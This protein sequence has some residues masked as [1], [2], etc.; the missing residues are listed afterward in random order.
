MQHDEHEADLEYV[1]DRDEDEFHS[2]SDQFVEAEPPTSSWSG[3]EDDWTIL[4]V[5]YDV[6]GYRIRSAQEIPAGDVPGFWQRL[7]SDKKRPVFAVSLED[8]R[9]L[10]RLWPKNFERQ[11]LR[12]NRGRKSKGTDYAPVAAK[13]MLEVLGARHG[14]TLDEFCVLGQK[15]PT[16]AER[17]AR[18]WLGFMLAVFDMADVMRASVLELTPLTK[19]QVSTLVVEGRKTIHDYAGGGVADGG[20][21]VPLAVPPFLSTADDGDDYVTTLERLERIEA[22]LT[23]NLHLTAD[24]VSRL[25]DTPVISQELSDAVDNFIDESLRKD[26]A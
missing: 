24:I 4:P 22:R 17:P 20:G 2:W 14:L 5:A 11:P 3:G 13:A 8:Q 23:E 10:R 26:K 25:C 1:E 12:D 16:K 6:S 15:K 7:E 18:E 21:V 9:K 19:M